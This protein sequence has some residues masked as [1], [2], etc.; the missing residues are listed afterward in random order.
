MP[1]IAF[2]ASMKDITIN[3]ARLKI[4]QITIAKDRPVIVFLHDSLGCIE[5]WRDFP[6]KLG[7]ATTC[8]VLIYDRQGYGKS[9][10]FDGTPR[11]LDYME[12]EAD[13]LNL[14]LTALGIEN[15]ILFGHSDGGS[16][17]LIAAAKYPPLIKGIITEGAHIFVEDISLNGIHQAIDTYNTTNLKQ[18]LEKYHGAKT[19]AVFRT[20]TGTWLKEE[21]QSWSIENFLPQITCPVLVIQGE[22]DEFG[23]IDQVDGI[24]K[25]V[26]AEANKLVIP[27][28]GHNP[29]KEMPEVM[30]EHCSRFI[31]KC[32]EGISR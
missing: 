18:R 4:K 28:A 24:A 23:S 3:G 25:Q 6:A 1:I 8:N 20:W 17:S 19:E 9:E 11:Q 13:V 30:L 15:A 2:E 21:F 16:I 5:L 26:S 10:P 29:H 22:N 12:K 7:E 31:K 27:S 14:L 32:I